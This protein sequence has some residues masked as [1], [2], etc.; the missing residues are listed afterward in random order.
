MINRSK[1]HP[2]KDHVVQYNTSTS[3]T[4]DSS[5]SKSDT[6]T[7]H[8]SNKVSPLPEDDLISYKASKFN[9]M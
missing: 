8:S 4:D 2:Q 9:K 5:D 7:F 3:D 6:I 1:I